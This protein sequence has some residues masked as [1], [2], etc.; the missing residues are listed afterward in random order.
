[1]TEYVYIE[2]SREHRRDFAR[3]CLEQT[4]KIQATTATGSNVPVDL[5]PSVP[6]ALLAGGRVDGFP[7]DRQAPQGKAPA[8]PKAKLDPEPEKPL[9]TAEKPLLTADQ[10]SAD[11]EPQQPRKRAARKRA[12]TKGVFEPEH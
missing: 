1:M 8:K 3:W 4:P 12:E 7:Y 2:P 5:Y 6:V 10:Q 9:L 11:L